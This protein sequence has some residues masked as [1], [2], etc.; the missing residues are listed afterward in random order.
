MR[1]TIGACI[2]IMTEIHSLEGHGDLI[3]KWVNPDILA[4]SP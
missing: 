3:G 4:K 2:G 1:P